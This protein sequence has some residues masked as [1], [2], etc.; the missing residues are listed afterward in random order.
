MNTE[1]SHVTGMHLGP[2]EEGEERVTRLG[3]WKTRSVLSAIGGATGKGVAWC[4]GRSHWEGC[5]SVPWAELLGR[6]VASGLWEGYRKERVAQGWDSL[7]KLSIAPV[8]RSYEDDYWGAWKRCI[9]AKEC[10]A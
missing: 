6:G 4:H 3:M 5:G 2:V 10:R 7:C 1:S 8:C 9:R